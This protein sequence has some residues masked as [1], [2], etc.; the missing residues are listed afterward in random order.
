MRRGRIDRQLKRQKIVGLGLARTATTSLHHAMSVLGISSAPDSAA[1][2]GVLDRGEDLDLEF[3]ARFDAFFDN[4]IPF[5]SRQL[6]AALPNARFVIT[7]RPK[8]EWLD[9]MRWLFGPGLDRLDAPTRELGDR[10]HR[11]VYGIDTFDEHVL[12]NIHERHYDDLRTWSHGRDDTLWLDLA[13][14]LS[15]EPLCSFIEMAAPSVA[16]PRS[17]ASDDGEEREGER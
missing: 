7:H 10:V 13:D 3:L 4:P 12:A 11:A 2:I 14:G 17:N 16:F 1:L 9:S 8:D 5:L 15:W 6:D